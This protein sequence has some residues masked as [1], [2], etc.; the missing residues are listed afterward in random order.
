M[1]FT[2]VFL[3]CGVAQRLKKADWGVAVCAV[4]QKK[5]KKIVADVVCVCV[6]GVQEPLLVGLGC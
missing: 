3:G 5:S 6:F 2:P 1:L 4:A